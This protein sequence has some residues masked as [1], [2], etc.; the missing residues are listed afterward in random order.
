MVDHPSPAVSQYLDNIE[1]QTFREALAKLRNHVLQNLPPGFTEEIS[2]GMIGYVVS[3]KLYPSG[4]HCNPKLPLPATSPQQSGQ[5]VTVSAGESLTFFPFFKKSFL[6]L[7]NLF[8][9]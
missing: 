9:N 4:Y 7:I 5:A 8:F 1:N 6:Q 2:Y 3:H